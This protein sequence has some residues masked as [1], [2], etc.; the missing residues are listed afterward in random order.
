M[1]ISSEATSW[2]REFTGENIQWHLLVMWHNCDTCYKTHPFH[3]EWLSCLKPG[4]D[5]MKEHERIFK[6][7]QERAKR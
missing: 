7:L 3:I 4:F 2:G 5:A 1:T 6:E